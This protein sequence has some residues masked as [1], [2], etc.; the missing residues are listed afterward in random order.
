MSGTVRTR[1]QAGGVSV[2][3]SQEGPLRPRA[4]ALEPQTGPQRELLAAV[5]AS[6]VKTGWQHG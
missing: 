2:S 5:R 3:D 6:G 1:D 4:A